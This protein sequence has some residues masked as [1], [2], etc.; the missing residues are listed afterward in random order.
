[1]SAGRPPLARA[2]V[3]LAWTHYR[4][5]VRQPVFGVVLALGL[6][7]VAASPALAV[8]SLGHADALVL[9]LGASALL[10][11][12]VFLAGA[13]VAAG[14]AER[15]T[16]GTTSLLL[17]QPIGAGTLL[18]GALLGAALA[19]GQAAL[20]LAVALA[21]AVR[22][23]PDT[24]HAGVL[25]G[26]GAAALGALGWGL[27]ASLRDRSFQEATI[28]AATLLFPLC[29]L[30]GQAIGRRGALGGFEAPP[31]L[32]LEAAALGV[33]AALAFTALGLALATRLGPGASAALTIACFVLSSLVRG[34]LASALGPAAGL[35]HLL[36]DLQLYW[37]GDAGYTEKPVPAEYLAQV[38]LY[39]GLYVA[40]WLGL[41]TTSL[42]RRELGRG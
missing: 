1:M 9:D 4:E 7:M 38:A 26:A 22:H 28:Q 15:L 23:G 10:F 36:P 2:L 8:F 20:L 24:W 40:V 42:A 25:L 35:T 30:L 32:V 29:F 3:G 27:R 31:H 13:A 19:L 33:Q 14:S 11:F 12:C 5:L 34:P 18:G 21:W 6:A 41:A 17:T 39:T 37:I 16:D